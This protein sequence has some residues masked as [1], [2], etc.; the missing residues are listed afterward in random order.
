MVQPGP[1][2]DYGAVDR[3]E[4]AT[5][6]LAI[7]DE[8]AAWPATVALRAWTTERLAP[9][10]GSRLLDIGCGAGEVAAALVAPVAPGGLVVGIDQSAAM[11]EAARLRGP[12]LALCRGDARGLGV[13]D[14]AV[15]LVR[16]ERTLQWVPDPPAAVAEA[17]RVLR[18]GGRLALL[19]TDW[20]TLIVATRDPR[21]E[22]AVCEH[23]A[24]ER[25]RPSHVGRRL[26]D[27][28]R[29]ARL[30]EVETTA[31]THTWDGWDP[32]T[33]PQPSG[34][35]PIDELADDLVTCGQL[36]PGD[37]AWFVEEVTAAARA[38]ELRMSLTM[39]AAVATTR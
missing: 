11:V 25:R 19:D 15:D 37:D 5:H 29:E 39:H 2:Y 27:L 21:V 24:V 36:G 1:E 32:D 3:G 18:P 30:V 7:I 20:S 8:A 23:V 17:V 31:R 9:G 6:L 12:A 22:T 16:C 38:G 14:E 10:P 35:F 4:N 34:F 13:R 28:C 26:G 33:E